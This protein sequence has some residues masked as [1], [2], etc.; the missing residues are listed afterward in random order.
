MGGGLEGEGLSDILFHDLKKWSEPHETGRSQKSIFLYIQLK[1][2]TL[3]SG[4]NH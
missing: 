1:K 3:R 4:K 2:K